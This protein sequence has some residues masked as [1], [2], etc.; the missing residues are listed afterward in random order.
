MIKFSFIVLFH[1]NDATD[2][3][4]D[5]ILEQTIPGDEII[6]VNDH[7]SE[8]RLKIFDRFDDKIMIVHSNRHGNRGYNRNYGATYASN[9][10][11]MFVDGDIIF[12]PNAIM[13]M[14]ESME[15]GNVGAVGNVICSSHTLTQMNILTGIDYLNLIKADQSFENIIKLNLLSDRRQK[16]L[17]DKIALN[18]VWEYF[19]TA[20]CAVEHAAFKDVGGFE[21]CFVGWGAEDDEFGYRL[22]LK[23]NLDYNTGAYAIHAPHQRNLYE[24]LVSNRINL[25]RF[26]AKYPTNEIAMHMC[27]GNTIKSKLALDYVRKKIIEAQTNIYDFKY[28][29]DCIYI[30]ELTKNYPNGYVYF[31]DQES[32]PHILELF[33]IALP[34]KNKNF[35]VSYCTE[36]L[37]IYPERFAVAIL[38]ELLRI[39]DNVHIIKIPNSKRIAWDS[40]LINGLIRITTSARITYCA[41][42][43]CDFDIEDCG[44][45]YKIADGISAKLNENFILDENFFH[46]EYFSSHPKHYILIN[47]TAT[48]LTGEDKVNIEKENNIIIDSCYQIDI[49]LPEPNIRL[50]KILYGDLYRLHTSIVYLIPHGYQIV[51][52]DR[53]WTFPSRQKDIVI[54]Q[55]E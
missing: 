49:K 47:L 21:T 27:F 48:K 15:K 9:K 4:I 54:I 6:V 33:G 36:N 26:L 23:G 1:N 32:N 25:Y 50:T 20:Y 34:F 19:Y 5:S 45:Y 8:K 37:F 29:S 3:V 12:M 42:A 17:Y 35:H 39:A 2:C 16:Q 38:T 18:S 28:E 31:M 24:C 13:A 10:Y 52:D 51:K 43:L 14:R 53:W 41:T 46:P 7:S 11:L 44:S 55:N 30:N 22:H 40:D